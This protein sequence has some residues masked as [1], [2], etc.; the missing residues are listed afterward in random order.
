MNWA[1]TLGLNLGLDCMLSGLL[2]SYISNNQCDPLESV[3][4]LWCVTNLSLAT[5]G[6]TRYP[7]WQ[8]STHTMADLALTISD[9][10][11]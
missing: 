9:N 6:V 8:L 1:G 11:N 5:G 3:L 7:M 4:T 10:G 2:L